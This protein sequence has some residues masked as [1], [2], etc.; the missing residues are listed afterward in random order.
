MRASL[1]PGRVLVF[2][3]LLALSLPAS[4]QAPARLL[5]DEP[6][7]LTREVTDPISGTISKLDE[8]CAGNRVVSVR[9]SR[10][11]IA[12]YAAGTLTE[13]DRAKGTYSV[14]SFDAIARAL[15]EVTST[16]FSRSGNAQAAEISEAGIRTIGG[17]GGRA[18]T[19]RVVDMGG[20]RTIEVVIDDQLKLSREAVEVLL[21]AAFPLN[22]SK[23]SDVALAAAARDNASA[24][25]GSG[26]RRDHSLP[27]EQ[28]VTFESEGESLRMQSRVTRVGNELPPS[29]LIAIPP[30]ARLVESDIILRKRMLDEADRLPGDQPAARQ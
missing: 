26:H 10:T 7:H 25:A 28:T 5:F 30:G 20:S 2:A 11:S 27:I 4:A 22:G 18:F 15:P 13:I 12:D 29:E 24:R 6:L 9:D 8:Y 17:R 19:S 1:A 3:F 16:P 21:G 14:T 23:E